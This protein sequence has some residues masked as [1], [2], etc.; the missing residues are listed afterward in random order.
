VGGNINI[1]PA[2]DTRESAT[3]L[4]EQGRKRLADFYAQWTFNPQWRLR[5]TVSNVAPLDY[6]TGTSILV[7]PA[8]L[9]RQRSVQ[10]SY[11]SYRLRV[12]ARL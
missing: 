9:E 10:A 5:F 7:D 8:T 4:N 1:T 12:E 2:F 6:Q 11:V 3:Q